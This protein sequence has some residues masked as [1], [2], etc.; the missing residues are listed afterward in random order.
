MKF[1]KAITKDGSTEFFNTQNILSMKLCGNNFEDLKI[2]MGAGLY[3][4]VKADTV[5]IV[6]LEE[7]I[8]TKE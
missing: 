5:E 6:D 8:K 7:V 3:W 2:L 4:L 1:L